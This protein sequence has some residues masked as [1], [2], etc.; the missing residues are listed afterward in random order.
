MSTCLRPLTTRCPLNVFRRPSPLHPLILS[1]TSLPISSS[2]HSS[3]HPRGRRGGKVSIEIDAFKEELFPT[4]RGNVL[5][6]DGL[7]LSEKIRSARRVKK[8]K[9]HQI[10]TQKLAN[11]IFELLH[12]ALHNDKLKKA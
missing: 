10:T 2:F 3:P 1:S 7:S 6:E 5:Y 4:R 8:R 11:S 9:M 12:F